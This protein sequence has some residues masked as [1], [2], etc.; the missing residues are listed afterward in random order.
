M[1]FLAWD[2]M[3]IIINII[4]QDL[5]RICNFGA[6]RYWQPSAIFPCLDTEAFVIRKPS[7]LLYRKS[8]IRYQMASPPC[9]ELFKQSCRYSRKN[10][11]HAVKCWTRW[12]WFHSVVWKETINCPVNKCLNF[13]R[14]PQSA[15][16]SSEKFIIF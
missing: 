5:V 13:F 4:Y 11:R 3:V 1:T 10:S 8:V 14:Q 12:F 15:N 16:I 9:L 2:K 6:I 7:F